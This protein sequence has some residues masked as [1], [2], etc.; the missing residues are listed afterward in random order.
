MPLLSLRIVARSGDYRGEGA[1]KWRSW[2]SLAAGITGAVGAAWLCL[3][4]AAPPE[5]WR[6][7]PRDR[8]LY[9]WTGDQ[10]R[11]RPDFLA[12]VDFNEHSRGYGKVIR[13]VPLPGPGASGN[14]P[15]HVAL[16]ADGRM[17]AA[18]GLLSVL[19]GQLEIF[20]FDLSHP[21]KPKLMSRSR[22]AAVE[23][24]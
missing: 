19:K 23:H 24:Y 8:Y 6:G 7:A 10:A 4:W 20:F 3:A 14:E 18:G 22:P 9:I 12:V 17:L 13:S 11:T 5:K 16:S 2:V 21:A 1:N 15:H